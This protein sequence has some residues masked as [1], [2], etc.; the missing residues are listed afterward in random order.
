M[1]DSAKKINVAAF[2]DHAVAPYQEFDVLNCPAGLGRLVKKLRMMP[3]EVHCV[4]EAG[5]NGYHLQRY[6]SECGIFCD[7]AAPSLTPRRAGNRV[8]TDPRD[9]KDLARLYRAGELTPIAIPGPRDESLRDLMRAREDAMENRQRARHRLN[10]FLMRRGVTY[11][12]GKAWTGKHNKWLKA[13]R[14]PDAEAQ[15]VLQ[16]YRL[17][18][19]EQDER[20]KRFDERIEETAKAPENR[21]VVEYLMGL[22]GIK[23][24]TAMTIVSEAIDLKR[25]ASARAFMAAVGMVS[26]EQ[27]SGARERR[28]RITK[29]GNAHIRRVVIESAWHYRHTSAAGKALKRRRAALPA[30]ILEIVRRADKR[31]SRRYWH[32]VNKGKSSRTAVVAV[33]RELLG[34]IWAV[35]QIA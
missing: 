33:A 7:V 20:M 24:L 30:E 13:V 21:K 15:M 1:D 8:K 16:E 26:Q 31:L 34:F 11:G 18:L 14:F 17:A 25:F 32:L 3:G 10:R 35:G 12:L 27:S 2:L 9:A 6:L 29:T 5:V 22:K 4:Y 28:G 23:V 19:Q